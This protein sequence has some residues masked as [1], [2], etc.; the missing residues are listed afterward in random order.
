MASLPPK[1]A[2]PK[3][4]RV[5]DQF[6]NNHTL[7]VHGGYDY[8]NTH[9]A[10]PLPTL[11]PPTTVIGWQLYY[12]CHAPRQIKATDQPLAQPD[13][14]L[15]EVTQHCQECMES[16]TLVNMTTPTNA[17]NVKKNENQMLK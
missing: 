8:A 7:A 17:H 12:N 14:H 2:T 10:L 15:P 16:K 11:T 13:A 1:Q 3:Q 6:G 4:P 5:A 9:L